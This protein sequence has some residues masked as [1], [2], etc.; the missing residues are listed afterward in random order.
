MT[1]PGSFRLIHTEHDTNINIAHALST[2][3]TTSSLIPMILNE[4]VALPPQG[5]AGT[6]LDFGLDSH[7]V[8]IL[9]LEDGRPRFPSL[10]LDPG[11]GYEWRV[12]LLDRLGES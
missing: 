9:A 1:D 4:Q 12:W 5:G 3:T 11:H 2:T 10:A 6:I 8:L 7:Y